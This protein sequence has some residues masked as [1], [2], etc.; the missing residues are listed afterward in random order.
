M[1]GLGVY[2]LSQSVFP[3]IIFSHFL[4]LSCSDLVQPDIPGAAVCCSE[5]HVV[6]WPLHKKCMR[7]EQKRLLSPRSE[8]FPD[9]LPIVAVAQIQRRR[10]NIDLMIVPA[11]VAAFPQGSTVSVPLW[12]F[13]LL[14]EFKLEKRLWLPWCGFSQQTSLLSNMVPFLLDLCAFADPCYCH[15]H[16]VNSRS[17]NMQGRRSRS[18]RDVA[19][20][21]GSKSD[22]RL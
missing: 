8:A 15:I 17:S 18:E 14:I 7:R 5:N 12:L 19:V 21:S 20:T 1:F 6:E 3:Q 9:A 2:L 22:Y 13:W 10:K 16:F 11:P 4:S